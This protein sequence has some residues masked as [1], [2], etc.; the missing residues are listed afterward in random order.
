MFVVVTRN[1][2]PE[3]G[4]MQSLMGG[5]SEG[6]LEHGPVKVFA[7]EFENSE[8][9]DNKSVYIPKTDCWEFVFD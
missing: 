5:L 7:N 3:I 6:L 2:P 9:Y 4:G 8:K 1:F